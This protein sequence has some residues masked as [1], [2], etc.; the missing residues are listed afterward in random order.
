MGE[1]G[2][3]KTERKRERC[4]N[5]HGGIVKLYLCFSCWRNISQVIETELDDMK[6][7]IR[8]SDKL[9]GESTGMGTRTK[10]KQNVK[11]C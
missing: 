3:R 1:R 8:R 10:L 6:T 7:E 11:I 5:T 2:E 4:E 9:S